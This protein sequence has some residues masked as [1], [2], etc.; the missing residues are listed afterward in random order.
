MAQ[1]PLDRRDVLTLGGLASLY[2]FSPGRT[3]MNTAAQSAG[4]RRVELYGLMGELPD[5][6][7][8]I[9]G[10]KRQ[11]VERDGYILETWDL[12]LNGIEPVPAYVARPRSRTGRAP[13]VV[14]DGTVAGHQTTEELL[15]RVK[16]WFENGSR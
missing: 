7:R 10:K 9:G 2:S 5:R 16:G 12:D 8:P 14:F 1:H 13:A 4:D 3:L 15:E 6:R 11:E